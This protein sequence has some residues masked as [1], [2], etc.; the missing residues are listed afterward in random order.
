[1]S[2]RPT[3]NNNS[4]YP[5]ISQPINHSSQL[6]Q[7]EMEPSSQQGFGNSAECNSFINREENYN[8]QYY[9]EFKKLYLTSYCLSMQLK[10]ILKSKD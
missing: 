4:Q 1:M 5:L 8:C 9:E 2:D 7:N 3:Q 6:Y 10:K